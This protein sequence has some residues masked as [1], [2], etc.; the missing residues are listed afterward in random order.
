MSEAN[1]P[2]IEEAPESIDVW[3]NLLKMSGKSLRGHAAAVLSYMGPAAKE[4][5]CALCEA[6]R[7]RDPHVRSKVLEAI[8]QI[9]VEGTAAVPLLIEL[10][11]DPDWELRR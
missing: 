4:A 9:G 11:G 1:E 10:L 7:D 6:F 5:V 3:V 8:C 2:R